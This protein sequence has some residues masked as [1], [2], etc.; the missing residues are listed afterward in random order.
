[1]LEILKETEALLEGH[2]LLS[3]GKHS[4]GYV[5][6]AK[7]LMYPDKAEIA[8]NTIVDKLKDLDFDLVLGPA[9]GG[10]IVSY[11]LARQMGK[12][13]IFSEREN[14]EMKLRRGFTIKKGQKVIIAEDVVTTGKS[15]Y[16]AIKVVEEAGGKVV[17]IACI[18]DRS[19]RDIKYP[20]YSGVNL[21]VNTYESDKCPLCKENIP[22]VKPGSRKIAGK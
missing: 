16:E 10:I 5:Q 21:D 14:G 1:M 8:I 20:I 7:L 15:A 12:P 6:C 22:V 11:E 9:M 19:S 2:F 4:D 17:G 18:V 3:S 13:S